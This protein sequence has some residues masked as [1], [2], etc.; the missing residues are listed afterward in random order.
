MT[1]AVPY[2]AKN[3]IQIV[4]QVFNVVKNSDSDIDLW[5]LFLHTYKRALRLADVNVG[6]NV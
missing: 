6:F 3:T 5:Y 4:S 1:H 2:F